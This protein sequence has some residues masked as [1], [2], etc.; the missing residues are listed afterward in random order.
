MDFR[1]D[2]THGAHPEVVEALAR[3]NLGNATSYAEDP[4]TLRVRDRLR[5]VFEHE[6]EIFPAV[7]GTAA[8]ALCIAAMTPPWGGVFCHEDAHIHRD[9][10]GATEFFTGGAKLFPRPG[11]GGK[12]NASDLDRAIAS[13]AQEGKSAEAACVSVTQATEA[14]GVYSLD[15]LQAIGAIARARQ[16]G[17]HM[18]GARFANA[19]VSLGC[20]AAD[21][22][23][24]AGVDALSFGATKNG[25]MAAEYVIVFRKE[26]AARIAPR[27]HRSGHRVSKSRFLSAQMDAYLANDLWL[28]SAAHANA[29]AKRLAA[30]FSDVLRPVEANVVFVRFPRQVADRLQAAGFRFYDWPIFGPDAYRLVTGWSTKEEEVDRFLEACATPA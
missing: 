28:R 15:E 2:N 1:S 11:A 27:W 8:N 3:V 26:L 22:T 4:I 19:L 18:D 20:S 14:G 29:M 9:E 6:L 10:L 5:Q 21:M 24:R 13:V 30:G 25:A 17:L 23:W 7:T 12:L 16:V